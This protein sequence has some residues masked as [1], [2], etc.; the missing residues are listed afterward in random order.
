MNYFS[1]QDK[2][3]SQVG[4]QEGELAV[5]TGT[6]NPRQ[7]G[8]LGRDT[9]K[10]NAYTYRW[11]DG[12][13]LELDAQF[14]NDRAGLDV[15]DVQAGEGHYVFLRDRPS[16]YIRQ[17]DG[18]VAPIVVANFGAIPL[19]V[20]TLLGKF[21]VQAG[22]M[23]RLDE[24]AP[25]REKKKVLLTISSNPEQALKSAEVWDGNGWRRLNICNGESDAYAG[26]SFI[27]RDGSAIVQQVEQ[28]SVNGKRKTLMMDVP[29]P[30]PD[31]EIY[32]T[33]QAGD[34]VTLCFNRTDYRDGQIIQRARTVSFTNWGERVIYDLQR[35]K[36]SRTQDAANQCATALPGLP[37]EG[38]TYSAPKKRARPLMS[39]KLKEFLD[40]ED[41]PDGADASAVPEAPHLESGEGNVKEANSEGVSINSLPSGPN[42]NWQ[43]PQ[44][45]PAPEPPEDFPE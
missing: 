32:V 6:V 37:P 23:L 14:Q 34:W 33:G 13:S 16:G 26:R 9:H 12:R 22:T 41:E 30:V 28:V 44:T 21:T 10:R 5:Y 1:Y 15:L 39:G 11:Q 38:E 25:Q 17:I 8:S 43:D 36:E 19:R 3:L 7:M 40:I 18:P 45:A 27:V 31:Y 4:I 35:L 24:N 29:E 42:W 20:D 2:E